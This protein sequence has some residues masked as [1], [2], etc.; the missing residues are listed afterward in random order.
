MFEVLRDNGRELRHLYFRMSDYVQE[1]DN[2]LQENFSSYDAMEPYARKKIQNMLTEYITIL[3]ENK[4]K[5]KEL[6]KFLKKEKDK[7]E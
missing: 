3:D 4:K 1:H 2:I 6:K 5:V 7:N